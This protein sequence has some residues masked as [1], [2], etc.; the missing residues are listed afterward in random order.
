MAP[1]RSPRRFDGGASA[2]DEAPW[3][4]RQVWTSFLEAFW[5]GLLTPVVILGGIYSGIFT[6]T[7]AAIVAAVYAIVL[8]FFV[9]RTLTIARLLERSLMR[10]VPRQ[11]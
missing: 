6:P 7:E 5:G 3:G 11:W 8:G 2:E 4:G 10:R 9:Y 1:N